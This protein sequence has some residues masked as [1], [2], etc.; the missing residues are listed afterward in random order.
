MFIDVSP[1]PKMAQNKLFSLFVVIICSYNNTT[2]QRK[3]THN[4]LRSMI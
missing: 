4:E 1:V 3:I 2:Y